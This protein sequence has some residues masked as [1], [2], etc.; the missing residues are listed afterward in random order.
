M[1]N[2]LWIEEVMHIRKEQ[3]HAWS[4]IRNRSQ[5]LPCMYDKRTAFQGRQSACKK[6]STF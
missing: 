5:Q 1:A 6:M 2:N 4:E 3:V